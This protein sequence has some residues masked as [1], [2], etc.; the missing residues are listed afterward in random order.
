MTKKNTI[1]L[2]ESEL[3]NIITES[4]KNILKEGNIAPNPE[5]RESILNKM[6]SVL[7]LLDEIQE[8]CSQTFD[9]TMRIPQPLEWEIYDWAK[10]TLEQGH[11]LFEHYI[12]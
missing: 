4:V 2:T 5:R 12:D 10:D 9:G 1:R 11:L 7:T 8:L 3:K 6:S